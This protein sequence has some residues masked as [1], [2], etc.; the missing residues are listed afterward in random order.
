MV[1]SISL[2]LFQFL[3]KEMGKFYFYYSDAF[4]IYILPDA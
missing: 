3:G 2:N 1:E 4:I